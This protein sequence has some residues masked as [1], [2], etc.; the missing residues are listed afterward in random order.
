MVIQYGTT[1]VPVVSIES[2]RSCVALTI[3][4][5][6]LAGAYGRPAAAAEAVD[7]TVKSDPL[8]RSIH[9]TYAVPPDAPDRIVVH[10]AWSAPRAD[11][12]RS[13]KVMPLIS[14]TALAML[15]DSEW[16]RWR[17]EGRIIERR[18]AG[19][20][21]TVVFNPYPEA[22]QNGRVNVDFRIRLESVDGKLLATRRVRVE[23]DNADVVTLEDW[24]RVFQ[25][26]ALAQG[27]EP[28]GRKWWWRTGKAKPGQGTFGNALYGK[29]HPELP[30]PQLSYPLDL[31][32]WYAIFVCTA[33]D[34]GSVRL[35]LTGDERTDQLGSRRAS[36]EMLWRWAVMD[37]QHLVLKQPHR[38]NG[39]APA[40]IDYVKLV[41]LTR[42]LVAQLESR[43]RGK[44]DKIV[45]GYWE[46]YSWAFHED[47]QETLQHREIL[48]AYRE[49]RVTLVDAQVNRFGAKAVFETR[50]A[51]QLLFDTVGDRLQGGA[52]PR[53]ANVGKMQQFT[54]ML[55]ATLRYARAL[56][57]QAHANFGASASYVGTPLQGDFSKQHAEWLRGSQLRFEVPEVR[58]YALR[59]VR[60]ALEIGAPGISIDFMRYPQTINRPATC[61]TF[62]QELRQLTDEFS[63]RRSRPVRILVQF[64]GTG[65]PP[66]QRFDYRTWAREGWVDYLCPSNDDERHLHLDVRPYLEAVQ[67]T[68][69]KLL[70]NVTAAGLPLPGLYLWRVAQLY[71]ACVDG[72][73]IYQSDARVL[74]RPAE[75]RCMRLLASSHDV[76][77]WWAQDKRLRPTRSKGIYI[78]RPSRPLKGWRSRERVRVWLEGVEMGPLEMHLDGKLVTR[79]EGPP[80]LLGTEERTSDNVLPPGEH[81]LRIRARDGDGWL[82]ECFT[83]RGGR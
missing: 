57:L 46:P 73:Y 61:N 75:R 39:W 43:F 8:T 3:C 32:G 51:D 42:D 16:Q 11:N 10:C 21:R 2:W 62:L 1:E 80:Y 58:R 71:D 22:Q 28:K 17:R 18:A 55:D 6:L 26:A 72:I 48:T 78:T 30:L 37:R 25:K 76:R 60:E 29:S 79:F 15:P 82:E 19:L 9:I 83:L 81:E 35:R 49:A 4:G 70:P 59:L 69:C 65:V 47:V 14:E 41:P 45:A 34:G 13:A 52:I 31:R 64:P 36:Q 67:G 27:A 53:T 5:G 33:S 56:G 44:R 68:Q 74:G 24:S 12:W 66:W 38:Y 20:R 23:V 54:N 40:S 77:A 63:K 7:A 50:R